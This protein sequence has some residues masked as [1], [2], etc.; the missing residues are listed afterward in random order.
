MKGEG[1]SVQCS[2]LK[3]TNTQIHAVKEKALFISQLV[4]F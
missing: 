4:Y 2:L 3:K 1:L